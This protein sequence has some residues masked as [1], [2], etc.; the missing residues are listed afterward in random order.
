MD[1]TFNPVDFGFEWTEDGWYEWDR[2]AGHEAARK[3]RKERMY[4]LRK[5]GYIVRKRTMAGQRVTV[6]G[7][8]TGRPQITQVV[9]IYGLEIA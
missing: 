7:I 8:G 3:A 6:G 4:E 5:Q 1:E 2:D 9:T